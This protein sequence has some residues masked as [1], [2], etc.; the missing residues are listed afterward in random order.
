MGVVEYSENYSVSPRSAS[1]E[2]SYSLAF[3]FTSLELSYSL[4]IMIQLA[5]VAEIMLL[6]LCHL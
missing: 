6:K 5:V 2:L 4:N 3:I 1:L